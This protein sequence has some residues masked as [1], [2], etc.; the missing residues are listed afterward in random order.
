MKAQVVPWKL[1]EPRLRRG[2]ALVLWQK[3]RETMA[4]LRQ[5]KRR[6][7][8][9]V[10]HTEDL[11]DW[12]Y[13]YLPCAFTLPPSRMHRWLARELERMVTSR[14]SRLNVLAPRGNAKSTIATLAFPVWLAVHGKEPYIW[15]V[16]ETR[17]Q[18]LAHLENI[19][20]ELAH[21]P[22][23]AQ[24]YPHVTGRTLVSRRQAIFLA[25]GVTIEAI[26]V[27]Q[28]LRG[29]RRLAH[30]PTLIVCDDIQN[31]RQVLTPEGRE[32]CRQWFF[33]TLIPAGSPETNI[34]HLATALHP[35][36]LAVELARRAGWRSRVFCSLERW[37][38]RMD[39]WRQWENIY[40]QS[41]D[42]E[43]A[44][45][46]RLFYQAHQADMEAGARVLWPQ[47]EDLYALMC[48]R[49]E[50]GHAAFEREKQNRPLLPHQ[51]EWPAEYF[52]GEIFF[53]DYPPNITLRVLALDPSQGGTSPNGD[54]SA[55]VL[56]ATAGDGVFYVEADLAR[57]PLP[58]MV[59][60]GV[61]L[62]Q[63]H[64][65]DVFAIE[66]NLFQSLL[67]DAFRQEF[68]RQGLLPPAVLLVTNHANKLLRIRRLGPSLA[69]RRI[70]FR[71]SH[72][73]TTLLLD[74]LRLFPYGDSDDGPDALELAIRVAEGYLRPAGSEKITGYLSTQ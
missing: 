57:R 21:N 74:Q 8:P 63:Q 32:R 16:S 39:L 19:K 6:A 69:A 30:R 58:Q 34:V 73:P 36:A 59:A 68:R 45:K 72:P 49:A 44:R 52:Q 15:I 67:G 61:A 9:R 29:K 5:Q 56:V 71:A 37:P 46:A 66:A 20:H 2:A 12:A 11:L 51:S 24:D 60:D 18:A 50:L 65:P 62:W 31:D 13:L 35:E 27:L 23:L 17:R 14:G 1:W 43:A 42:R 53:A 28:A 70:R 38:I 25:N 40:T 47:R 4:H 3:F 41:A 26:G 33:G 7:P 55:Y 22:L 64:R 10:P 48:L 54:Y